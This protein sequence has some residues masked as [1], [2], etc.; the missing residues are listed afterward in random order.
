MISIGGNE[1][2]LNPGDFFF[3]KPQPRPSGREHGAS[4]RHGEE[5]EKV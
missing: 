2:F 1:I 5:A 3:L 4:M